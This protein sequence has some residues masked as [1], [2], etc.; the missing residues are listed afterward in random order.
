MA[1]NYID[2]KTKDGM[3]TFEVMPMDGVRASKLLIHLIEKFGGAT[4]DLC[5]GKENSFTRFCALI[6]PA[7]FEYLMKEVLYSVNV[8][9][10]SKTE[11]G[12]QNRF[13]SIFMGRPLDLMKLV[14]FGVQFNLGEGLQD[15]FGPVLEGLKATLQGAME[16]L[17]VNL[18]HTQETSPGS[19]QG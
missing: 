15:F 7:E 4:W 3:A 2:L 9:Y 18:S 5:S 6:N 13:N 17:A 12:V 19:V 16:N 8:K 14:A 11:T 1:D 10:E